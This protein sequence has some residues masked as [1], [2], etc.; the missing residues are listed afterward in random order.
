MTNA[1]LDRNRFEQFADHLKNVYRAK[2]FVRFPKG[3]FLFNFVAG[4]WE[5]EPFREEKTALVFIGK[6]LESEK[7]RILD[8]LRECEIET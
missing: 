2:G 7:P 8:E 6:G 1:L 5:L 4:R 3:S